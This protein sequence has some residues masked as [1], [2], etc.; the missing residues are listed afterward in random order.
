ML[1]LTASL[2]GCGISVPSDPNGTLETVTDGELRVGMSAEPGLVN[3]SGAE[4]SGVL[5]DLAETYAE[6]LNA[7]PR[8]T[9]GSEETLVGLLEDGD[10]DLV[11]GGFTDQ[12]PWTEHA[13]VTRGY[14]NIEGAR[15]RSLVMLVPLGENAFLSDVE[16]FL[17]EEV[18]S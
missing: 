2:V 14:R 3:V 12:T 18:G 9:V 1:A 11:I 5:V 16:S 6:T 10:L 15:G 7:V 13:G 17:D 4:P 8:W